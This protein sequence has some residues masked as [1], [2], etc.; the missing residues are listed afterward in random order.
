[1][2]LHTKTRKYEK[3]IN[4]KEIISQLYK[5]IVIFQNFQNAQILAIIFR[6][7]QMKIILNFQSFKMLK[8]RIKF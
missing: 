7:I 8:Y 4:S 5:K 1:M 2:N 6:L 3:T